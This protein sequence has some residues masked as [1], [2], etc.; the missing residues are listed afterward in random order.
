MKKVHVGSGPHNLME[1]WINVDIRPFKGL[2][3]VLDVTREWPFAEVDYV[4]GEHFI[5]HLP[6]EGAIAFLAN[7]GAS[8]KRGGV[9]RLT[10]PNLAE[11]TSIPE[12]MMDLFRDQ[13]LK[14]VK[15]GH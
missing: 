4:Y 11:E 14:Y 8:L 15:S 3:R 6:L 1:G 5:E 12:N 13:F 2:D 9:L 7:A 10:T